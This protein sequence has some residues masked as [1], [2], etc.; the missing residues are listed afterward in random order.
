MIGDGQGQMVA[1]L[2]GATAIGL[3]ALG[4]S[5]I[6]SMF[7]GLPYR[8]RARREGR[9]QGSGAALFLRGLLD[10]GHDSDTEATG[11]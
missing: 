6:I 4:T 7:L 1:Q 2:A 8:A 5:L 3:L 9:S 10:Q 11:S